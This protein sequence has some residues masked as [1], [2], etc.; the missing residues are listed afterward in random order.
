MHES[1]LFKAIVERVDYE[2]NVN[3]SRERDDEIND[4]NCY[5]I[6][7]EIEAI[8]LC[9]CRDDENYV[10]DQANDAEDSEFLNF[11]MIS[12]KSKENCYF[13]SDILRVSPSQLPKST[14]TRCESKSR[15]KLC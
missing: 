15:D 5:V 13:I 1:F 11:V 2:V 4:K 14:P 9:K 8:G 3:L 6:S 7:I 12:L 10:E